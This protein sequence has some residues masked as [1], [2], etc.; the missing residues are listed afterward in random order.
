MASRNMS[1]FF[2]FFVLISITWYIL[3]IVVR[4]QIVEDEKEDDNVDEEEDRKRKMVEERMMNIFNKWM[5][6]HKIMLKNHLKIKEEKCKKGRDR[7]K[8]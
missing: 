7:K 2:K 6:S 3:V 1:M 8:T 5:N 4:K